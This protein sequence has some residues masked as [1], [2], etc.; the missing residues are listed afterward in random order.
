MMWLVGGVVET[1]QREL[2]KKKEKGE[3]GGFI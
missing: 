3:K 2:K 1:Y